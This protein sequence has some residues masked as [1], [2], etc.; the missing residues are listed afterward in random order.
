MYFEKNDYANAESVVRQA[1]EADPRSNWSFSLLGRIYTAQGRASE[2]VPIFESLRDKYP[3]NIYPRWQLA[4]IY[5]DYLAQTDPEAYKRAYEINKDLV[6]M[7]TDPAEK[8]SVRANFVDCN[9]TTGRY[10][11]AVQLAQELAA[12]SKPAE[13]K[14]AMALIAYAALVAQ[15]DYGQ[16]EAKLT[17]LEGAVRTLQP[18]EK[19][20]WEYDGTLNY[21]Q[22]TAIPDPIKGSLLNLTREFNDW[23]KDKKSL[24]DLPPTLFKENRVSLQTVARQSRI[25]R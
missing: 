1:I 9:L 13:Y 23:N 22:R 25:L 11:E 24:K 4:L 16:A 21:L 7:A 19:T 10:R 5:Q 8:E 12:N 14:I 15:R 20:S 2:A 3:T 17:E 18:G 6:E